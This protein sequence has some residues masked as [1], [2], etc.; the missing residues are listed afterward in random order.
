MNRRGFLRTASGLVA[1]LAMPSI[2]LGQEPTP[3]RDSIEDSV[4]IGDSEILRPIPISNFNIL[5][6]NGFVDF[7]KDGRF[8]FPLEC[9]GVKNKFGVTENLT[10]IAQSGVNNQTGK[11]LSINIYDS[12]GKMVHNYSQFLTAS[13]LVFT[14]GGLM[15]KLR[16]NGIGN[17]SAVAT[18]NGQLV[19]KR[20]FEIGAKGEV[21]K[22]L[23]YAEK[24]FEL[25]ACNWDG[26]IDN[27]GVYER[28]NFFGI[29]DEFNSGERLEV[30]GYSRIPG[31][32]GNTL[33]INV[34]DSNGS[35]I[36][37]FY[38][39]L[40]SDALALNSKDIMPGI[41]RKGSGGMY[42]AIA[43]LGQER[44]GRLVGRKDFEVK[45]PVNGATFQYEIYPIFPE[46]K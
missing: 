6:C 20:E 14:E 44:G 39:Y 2:S 15:Q 29:K 17:Y 45:E 19:G 36:D 21:P 22:K 42:T 3:P 4:Q 31:Q 10:L 33:S 7:D 28:E 40:G 13:R 27:N 5:L 25:F 8:W 34:Y 26:D 32:T 9:L 43:T 18:L 30:V 46:L 11:Q 41:L 1:G 35:V 23:D 37:K 12:N 38:S 24:G 16:D